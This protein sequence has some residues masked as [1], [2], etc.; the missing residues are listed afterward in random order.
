MSDDLDATIEQYHRALDGFMRSDPR[1]LHA[2]YSRSDY[3]T[4]ANPFGPPRRGWPAVE[5]T[6]AQA[7][8]HFA[9]G[10]AIGFDEVSRCVTPELAYIVELERYESKVG[11]GD[12]VNPHSSRVTTVFRREGDSWKIVHRH[13]DGITAARPAESVI[14]S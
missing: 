12:N 9:D 5:E 7:A 11:G 1:P 8:S 3:V 4:I 2:L 13:A 14:Q 10:R 6:T